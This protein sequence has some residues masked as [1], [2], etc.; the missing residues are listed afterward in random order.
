LPLPVGLE[1]EGGNDPI[2]DENRAHE[3]AEGPL[4]MGNVGFEPILV[5]EEEAES[6]ARRRRSLTPTGATPPNP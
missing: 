1:V 3:I 6:L 5:I 2:P 4:V